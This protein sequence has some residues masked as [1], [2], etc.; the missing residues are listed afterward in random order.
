[1]SRR[2]NLLLAGAALAFA[3]A[4]A[5]AI[6]QPAP[7]PGGQVERQERTVI[8][9]HGGHGPVAHRGHGERDQAEH[10]K[11]LLQLRP[12]Q[13]AALTSYLASQKMDHDGMLKLADEGPAKTTP[14]RLA[15]MDR[16]LAQMKARLDAT[17]RFYDQLDA[18]QKRAFD[19]LPLMMGGHMGPM[20]AMKIRH[21]GAMPGMPPMHG[22]PMPPARPVPPVPP[23]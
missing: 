19:E 1:M 4:G 5:A 16:H 9:R 10:L 13:E 2:N 18:G 17:R 11:N 7:P 14:E 20:R 22:M 21:M 12:N 23:T 8:V 15:R 6:A 3:A